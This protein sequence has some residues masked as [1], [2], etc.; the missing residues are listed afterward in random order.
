[1]DDS[2][3]V[4]GDL[5]SWR[6]L[7]RDFREDTPEVFT[8]VMPLDLSEYGK[9]EPMA[10][11]FPGLDELA[12]RAAALNGPAVCVKGVSALLPYLSRASAELERAARGKD[13]TERRIAVLSFVNAA[14]CCGGPLP[15]KS[16]G[17]EGR[18][19]ETLAGRAKG[20]DELALRTPGFAAVATDNRHLVE[21][22]TG[23][24]APAS[25]KPG[26]TF[27]GN[28]RGLIRYLAAARAR[29]APAAFVEPAWHSFVQEFPMELATETLGWRDLLWCA[30]A[31]NVQ[32]EHR[33]VEKTADS[34]HKLVR[35][36]A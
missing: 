3:E 24:P 11:R 4:A 5:P 15:P 36:L 10:P 23:R 21:A 18:W 1:M 7:V 34:L 12:A 30:R 16:D 35:T 22:F 9:S 28:M 32:F 26:E 29:N 6:Q 27:G 13:D 25:V 19:L 20:I 8:E 31:V 17:L 14:R 2:D 33:P